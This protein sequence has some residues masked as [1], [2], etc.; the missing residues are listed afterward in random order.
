MANLLKTTGPIEVMVN[1]SSLSINKDDMGSNDEISIITLG[2]LEQNDEGHYRLTYT[3]T[4]PDSGEKTVIDLNLS[5]NSISMERKGSVSVFMLFEKNKAFSS[6]YE[7][8][9]GRIYLEIFTLNVAWS[10]QADHGIIRLAYQIA[11]DGSYP[12]VQNLVIRFAV[13]EA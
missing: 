2:T 8:E 4:D 11:T 3:E 1:I 9:Y 12:W 13:N 10:I 5:E 6:Y 7:T